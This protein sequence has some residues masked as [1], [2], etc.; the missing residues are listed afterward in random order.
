MIRKLFHKLGNQN[1][2]FLWSR[3]KTPYWLKVVFP[4]NPKMYSVNQ[5]L[6]IK[7]CHSSPI[8]LNG[9]NHS[10][11]SLI[12]P[13]M[14]RGRRW[15]LFLTLRYKIIRIIT[16]RLTTNF[17]QVSLPSSSQRKSNPSPTEPTLRSLE[18]K[19]A[20]S[21]SQTYYRQVTIEWITPLDLK[22]TLT[23]QAW[24][25]QCTTTGSTPT[26]TTASK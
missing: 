3:P 11:K 25:H 16:E 20:K 4:Q 13:S 5:F 18:L 9:S 24:S 10:L 12:K 2:R 19:I 17:H 6:T 7:V 14:T 21:M 8:T 23:H 15:S 1:L 26:P 22:C